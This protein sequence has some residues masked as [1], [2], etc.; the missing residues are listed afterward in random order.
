MKAENNENIVKKDISKEIHLVLGFSNSYVNKITD[1]FI[2][3]LKY[4]I[5][6]RDL[7][8]KNFGSFKKIHKKERMGRN[9]KNSQVFKISS[10]RSLSFISSKKLN[11]KINNLNE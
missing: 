6:E 4:S 3:I 2:N 9:P 10:R 8:I 11:K 1:D 7:N 5:I